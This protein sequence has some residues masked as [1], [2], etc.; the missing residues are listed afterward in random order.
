MFSVSCTRSDKN[1]LYFK[2]HVFYSATRLMFIFKWS[3]KSHYYVWHNCISSWDL[4]MFTSY[5]CLFGR[6]LFFMLG[7]HLAMQSW[8]LHVV[9][10]VDCTVKENWKF[11][12]KVK[13]NSTFKVS[14]V[15]GSS[16]ST[17]D[18]TPKWMK[19]QFYFLWGVWSHNDHLTKLTWYIFFN[20]HM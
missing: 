18:I 20:K 10:W 11:D 8:W 1:S 6:L 4:V 2:K 7:L 16:L 14:L 5:V 9:D 15:V 17:V 19:N 12:S 13:Q 3:T